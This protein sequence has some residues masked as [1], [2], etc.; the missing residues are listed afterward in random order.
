M[1]YIISG[2]NRPNSNSLKLANIVEKK[3][4]ESNVNAEIIDL[5]NMPLSELTGN[6]YSENKPAWLNEQV[7]KINN[8]DGLYLIVPE[9][10]GSMPGALKLFIDHLDYPIAFQYRPVCF[11]G[12]G[13]LFGGLRPVEHC[14]Q[15]FSYRNAFIYPDRVFFM[16]V[17]TSLKEGKI[18]NELEAN[19]LKSQI[20][21]FSHFVKVLKTNGLH[22]LTKDK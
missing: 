20:L 12:L 5:Q 7:Q 13:G 9:Y 15:V 18:E 11:I 22:S 2:T 6:E 14:M 3:F 17:W 1:I 16:N 4:S 19:L 10:N 8:S 21:G